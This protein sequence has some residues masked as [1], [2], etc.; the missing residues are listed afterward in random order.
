MISF[1]DFCGLAD[2]ADASQCVVPVYTRI[3]ADLLTPVSAFLR[4]RE[5]G[6]DAF[7]LESVEG[8]EKLARY[9]FLGADPY[10]V[11]RGNV[12]PGNRSEVTFDA[13]RPPAEHFPKEADDPFDALAQ[14]IDTFEQQHVD[15]LPRFTGGAVGFL[16]YDC[17]RLI[18]DLPF[19][20]DTP[21]GA[22]AT[23]SCRPA[24]QRRKPEAEASAAADHIFP[25][26]RWCFYDRIVAFDHLR[27]QVV[28]IAQA[29][30]HPDADRRAAYDTAAASVEMLMET[31]RRPAGSQ[32][33]RIRLRSRDITSNIG[34]PQ[35]E[36]A[37]ERAK[38][39]IHAGDIFQVVLSQRF[40]LAYEGDPLNLYR[41]LR[42]V[43]P[44]PYLFFL[45]AGDYAIAGSS[46]E[47]LVRVEE[48]RAELL[49]IAGTRPRGAT[50]D[51]DEALEKDL[52]ADTKERAEHLMLVDLGRN[53][54]GRVCRFGSIAVDRYAYVER[55][56]HVMHIVSSMS[57]EINNRHAPVDVLRACFPAGTV[58]G[59]PK[60]RA[61]EIIDELEP[62]RRG[63]YAGAV[64]Y[65]DF[66]GAL[67]TCIAIRTM[68]IR[69]DSI[70]VQ[71]GAGIV[72]DSD[73]TAEFEETKNKAAALREAIAVA[74][75]S[76]L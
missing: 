3:S 44:S 55:Y 15:G 54:L 21:D 47:V 70:D 14:C 68:V 12:S 39:Y 37:V 29:F 59:A 25:D 64:G 52:L 66:S 56:S 20:R 48:G 76:F 8:G 36:A 61:M 51:E 43:N 50:P 38:E 26:A 69:G 63:L 33:E 45:D 31:L 4:L 49:P 13:R 16:G 27:H 42:Q 24:T 65:V 71:A 75:E 46:P 22:T 10:L 41:A 40:S 74:G 35:F 34:R 5:T 1:D 9:S 2:A 23:A 11:V 57:G 28:L 17:V 62:D 18:E 6:P 67:D 7:L 32:P 60:V 58:S 73:P 53:D 72:A 30:L 19:D